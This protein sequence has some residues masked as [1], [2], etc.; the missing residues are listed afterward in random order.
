M[1]TISNGTLLIDKKVSLYFLTFWL[2]F[3]PGYF[4]IFSTLK[5][6][7]SISSYVLAGILIISALTKVRMLP[8]A[9]FVLILFFYL[10]LIFVTSFSD[11]ST[12]A[13]VR[14]ALPIIG[15]C[16]FYEYSAS[17]DRIRIIRALYWIHFIFSVINLLTIILFPNG[18]YTYSGASTHELYFFLGHNNV[19]GRFLLPGIAYAVI[20][21]YV[22]KDALGWKS[23]SIALI[24]FVNAILSWSVTSM[25]GIGIVLLYLLFGSKRKLPSFFTVR[26]LLIAAIIVF[27]LIVVENNFGVFEYII[28]NVFQ[29]DMTLSART[30]I[31]SAV[32]ISIAERSLFGYGYGV[33]V[34]S[35]ALMG[36]LEPSSAHNYFL[37]LM[38]RGGIIHFL[39]Q[40]S[41]VLVGGKQ[42]SRNRTGM[43]GALIV[44][45]LAYFIM[46]QFEPFVNSGYL[47]MMLIF[48]IASNVESIYSNSGFME[49]SQL[50]FAE[51]V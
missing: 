22:D 32:L 4:S 3:S 49:D 45:F 9:Q 27:V 11:G 15:L 31:W 17:E 42:I 34:W 19:A 28:V 13:S 2:F 44:I 25:V 16:G 7:I 39:L 48:L 8:S 38:F 36:S 50:T 26:N 43:S 21:D 6:A 29:K 20:C 33:N 46:W 30:R 41:I 24:G 35:Y 47:D 23:Y 18:L 1:K 14:Y 37:D 40:I 10:E 5:S 51:G 12:F